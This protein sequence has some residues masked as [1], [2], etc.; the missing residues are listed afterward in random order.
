LFV[1]LQAEGVFGILFGPKF[2]LGFQ[3][4]TSNHCL[5]VV[6]WTIIIGHWEGILGIIVGSYKVFH[7][8]RTTSVDMHPTCRACRRTIAKFGSQAGLMKIEVTARNQHCISEEAL[9]RNGVCTD[10]ASGDWSS[11]SFLFSFLFARSSRG[12]TRRHGLAVATMI[13]E[14]AA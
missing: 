13:G 6:L 9:W 1:V 12:T 10:G 14:R 11:F 2:A 8:E 7:G 3:S 4:S 5:A